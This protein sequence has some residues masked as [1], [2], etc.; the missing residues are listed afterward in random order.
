METVEVSD[1]QIK[2]Y[3]SCPRCWGYKKILKLDPA[4]DK[5]NLIMGD[6]FHA[7]AEHYV[8]N[9]SLELAQVLVINKIQKGKPED[10]Q[11]QLQVV[12]AMLTG[13][14]RHWLPAFEQE[15][16]IIK[17]E[18]EFSYFPHPQVKYR[19]KKDLKARKRSTGGI[20]IGDYKTSSKTTIGIMTQE[21]HINRQ[22]AIYSVDEMRKAGAWPQEVALIFA[23]KPSKKGKSILENAQEA[24]MTPS[25][26]VTKTVQVTP[27]FAQFAIDVEASDVLIAHQMGEYREL[28]KKI[29][30]R[31]FEF[32]P[33]NVTN[34]YSYG[35]ECGFAKGCHSGNPCHRTLKLPNQPV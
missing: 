30:L 27:Q 5:D 26:Y 16:E 9:R 35:K 7:G 19:G 17:P 25:N 11:W 4:E 24:M 2:S 22:L 12:P 23:S 10:L 18:E 28:Y 6:A 34:C 13:W 8:L 3:L 31:A 20:F 15:Y 32:I 33:P 1:S 14:A 29:G 21:L